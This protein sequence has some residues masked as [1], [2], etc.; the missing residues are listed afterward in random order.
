MLFG[1]EISILPA[2]KRLGD[3]RT[4]QKG[5]FLKFSL[6]FCPNITRYGFI[7][8]SFSSLSKR[9]MNFVEDV[10]NSPPHMH[11]IPGRS[12]SVG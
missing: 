4:R 8:G 2:I 3:G 9:S 11:T 12:C 7:F 6:A 5:Q 10:V 1:R